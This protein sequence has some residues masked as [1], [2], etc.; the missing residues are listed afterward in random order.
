MKK[1]LYLIIYLS[2]L[3]ICAN[4]T[5]TDT[6]SRNTLKL[7]VMR[8]N[9]DWLLLQSSSD[10]TVALNRVLS[11]CDSIIKLDPSN[12]SKYT[13]YFNKC[14]ALNALGRYDEA[15]EQ[16]ELLMLTLPE[17][18]PK[19]NEFMIS[20]YIRKGMKDS[21][22][23]YM[24]KTIRII[25]KTLENT[26]GESLVV[27]K[28]DIIYIRNGKS[29][30]YEYITNTMKSHPQKNLLYWMITKVDFPMTEITK[31]IHHAQAVTINFNTLD[32]LIFEKHI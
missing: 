25:D 31:Q 28:A 27:M 20:K 11:L 19:R 10:D 13:C 5:N 22:D 26:F 1:F 2:I 29:A 30:A 9:V 7:E 32:T 12:E 3:F 15:F 23:Y 16:Q 4:C 14:T 24:D 8:I 6:S 21:A 17:D 18:N